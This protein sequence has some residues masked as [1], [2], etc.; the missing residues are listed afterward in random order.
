[1]SGNPNGPQLNAAPLIT[2]AV[3]VGAGAL[4][5]MAGVAIG[6]GHLMTATRRWVREMDVTPSDLARLKW[7]QARSA[8]AAGTSAWQNGS[9][10]D[11]ASDVAG[12][13]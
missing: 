1:M 3:M 10:V 5:V 8:V 4:I 12:A 2:S 11:V 7:A 6:S 9:R 13:A